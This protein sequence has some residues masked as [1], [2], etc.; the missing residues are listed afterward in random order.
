MAAAAA[1]EQD[2]GAILTDSQQRAHSQ[3]DAVR[4]QISNTLA[5]MEQ[6]KAATAA[7]A[8]STSV[9]GKRTLGVASGFAK[10]DFGL[11]AG[12][13]AKGH[14]AMA[15]DLKTIFDKHEDVRIAVAKVK[16][17]N[18]DLDL[19][20]VEAALTAGEE[21]LE[22]RAQLEFVAYTFGW[23]AANTFAGKGAPV[24]PPE[25]E[26]KLRAAVSAA[27][28]AKS[29]GQKE[30]GARRHGARGSGRGGQRG[31]YGG[32]G[33]VEAAPYAQ[34]FAG[35]GRGGQSHQEPVRCFKCN[36]LGH[37]AAKCPAK[38]GL[39]CHVWQARAGRSTLG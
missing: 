2:A 28:Q 8:A 15:E 7:A 13:L 34:P 35:G 39:A 37:F 38:R 9:L 19:T 23:E 5:A 20:A 14:A 6:E 18:P 29:K 33:P 26:K 1:L 16:A 4:L 36:G 27:N 17:D 30:G 22:G 32:G 10:A 12:K 31:A 21:F 11:S 25:Q 24:L 3:L